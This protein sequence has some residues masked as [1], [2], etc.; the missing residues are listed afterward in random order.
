MIVEVSCVLGGD[1]R[2]LS[3]VPV[4]HLA[5]KNF[6][7]PPLAP[8][9]AS[10]PDHLRCSQGR[11]GD[12]PQNFYAFVPTTAG[13]EVAISRVSVLISTCQVA[14]NVSFV[15]LRITSSYSDKAFFLSLATERR[16]RLFASASIVILV[17]VPHLFDVSSP[18]TS[19]LYILVFPEPGPTPSMLHSS[20]RGP[21]T[22][23]TGE[24]EARRS[25]NGSGLR[26]LNTH[27]IAVNRIND[28]NRIRPCGSA[29]RA[30]LWGWGRQEVRAWK[31]RDQMKELKMTRDEKQEEEEV[32]PTPP[33]APL[34]LAPLPDPVSVRLLPR[35]LQ[36]HARISCLANVQ[37]TPL[38]TSSCKH[39][40]MG[41]PPRLQ[42]DSPLCCCGAGSSSASTVLGDEA[43]AV[44]SNFGEGVADSRATHGGTHISCGL[45]KSVDELITRQWRGGTKEGTQGERA[46]HPQHTAPDDDD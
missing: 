15:D 23:S 1:G 35:L 4:D 5:R 26:L 27:D 44:I 16:A 11:I 18:L 28:R 2:V 25:R 6:H 43:R 34:F 46:R 24:I 39:A 45:T 3:H 22:A 14:I 17:P 20:K 31:T 29:Y 37:T 38:P 19:S 40:R 30:Y 8:P 33:T 9:D 41:V 36:R 21:G 12:L 7:V 42:T 10:V 32:S 13:F